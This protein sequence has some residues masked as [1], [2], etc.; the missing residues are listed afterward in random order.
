[1]MG[2]GKPPRL[3][4]VFQKYDPPLYFVTMCTEGRRKLL[5]NERVHRRL[6]EY[7][8]RGGAR[9]AGLGR[10][11]IMADHIHLFVRGALDFRLGVWVRGLKRVVAAAVLG[12]RNSIQR[13]QIN[14]AE[15]AASTTLGKRNTLWQRGFFDHVIR[16]SESYAQKWNYL[17]E[18]PVRDGLVRVAEEWAFQGEIVVID[19]A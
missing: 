1:M 8:E 3:P 7:G 19:R 18:N 11:V 17:R 12:G 13:D 10:Y 15:T 16:N 14:A 2:R 4:W 6:V 9:G 5:A